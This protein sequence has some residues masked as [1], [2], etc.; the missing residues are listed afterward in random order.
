MHTYRKAV[1]AGCESADPPLVAIPPSALDPA[2]A[3]PANQ[4]NGAFRPG[5]CV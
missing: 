2:V 1:A 3:T 5:A 4:F